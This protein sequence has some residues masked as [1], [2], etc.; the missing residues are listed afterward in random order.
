MLRLTEGHTQ[1]GWGGSQILPQGLCM[2]FLSA[3]L[4]PDIHIA[5]AFRSLLK[6]HLLSEAFP[7]H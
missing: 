3:T 4:S 2:C 1:R 7:D 5:P 6:F